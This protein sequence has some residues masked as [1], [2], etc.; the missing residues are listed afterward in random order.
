MRSLWPVF[1]GVLAGSVYFS[2]GEKGIPTEANCS[3]L[4]PVSTDLA[5]LIAGVY[6]ANEGTNTK[7][8]GVA[9]I[10]AAVATIHVRQFLD[11][12]SGLAVDNA[13]TSQEPEGGGYL[14]P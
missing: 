8:A 5:A 10:G 9:F 14:I 2:E 4:S 11:H 3:Y 1:F 13:L 12:K 7:R 6:L